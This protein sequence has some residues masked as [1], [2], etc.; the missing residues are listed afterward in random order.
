METIRDATENDAVKDACKKLIQVE[1]YLLRGVMAFLP[2]IQQ[3]ET[4]PT[5]KHPEHWDSLSYQEKA[6]LIIAD[7]AVKLMELQCCG[8]VTRH[9]ENGKITNHASGLLDR[10]PSILG[11]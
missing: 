5:F 6:N 2:R 10:K 3:E 7:K 9:R 1:I 8:S 11:G 4:N